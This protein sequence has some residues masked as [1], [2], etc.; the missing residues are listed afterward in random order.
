MFVNVPIIT[1]I[2]GLMKTEWRF[3]FIDHHDSIELRLSN[4]YF[5][6]KKS[7]RHGWKMT[8]YWNRLDKR[9]NT[10]CTPPPPPPDECDNLIQKVS[11]MIYVSWEEKEN[12]T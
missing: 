11:K 4:Y 8:H 5:Y 12:I 10:I 1:R 2:D 3:S 9:S 7:T 6:E